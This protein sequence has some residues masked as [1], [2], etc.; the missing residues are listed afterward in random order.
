MLDITDLITDLSIM[1]NKQNTTTMKTLTKKATKELY[2]A[3]GELKSLYKNAINEFVRS[4]KIYPVSYSGRGRHVN[5][6][7]MNHYIKM[8]LS[9][10]GY[11]FTEGNDAPRGGQS[12]NFIKVSKTALNAL[13]AL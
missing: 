12:G 5:V 9:L 11:K 3:K 13:R 8:P 6:R 7:D 10:M 1:I 2:T 4:E